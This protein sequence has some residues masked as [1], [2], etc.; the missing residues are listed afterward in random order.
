MRYAVI[1]AGGS[2]KRLWPLSRQ[3]KPKQVLKLIEGQTL[4]RKCFERLQGIFEPANILVVTN[5]DYV[6][7]VCDELGELPKENIVAEPV[8][9]DTAGAI[10]LAATILHKRDASAT[11]AVVTADQLLEP[12]EKFR[13]TLIAAISFIDENPDA[14]I[15]FGIK[16]LFPSTQ[17]GY[18][19]FGNVKPCAKAAEHVYAIDTFK[20][21]PNIETATRYFSDGHFFWNAGLF[22]CRCE[23]IL[24][25]LKTFLPDCVEPL[26]KIREGWATAN[27]QKMLEEW[28]PKLPKISIDYAVMEKAP[29]VHGMELDCRWMDLGSFS[30]LQNIIPPD[31][32]QNTVAAKYSELL[33]SKNNIIATE[34]NGHLIALIGVEN[35]IVAH[36]KDA[37]LVCPIDQADRLKELL[38]VIKSH[39]CEQFL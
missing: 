39:Q 9:R 23:T 31:H 22:V 15:T 38:D 7:T 10:G 26:A 13:Q 18:L 4:L 27:Q 19:K 17:F 36:S 16:P 11:M 30:A 29:Q 35:M 6:E 20:E 28:F 1:M 37:T 5:A 32:N 21:K 12:A 8:V 33:N 14:M 24:N 25:H 3:K 34:E 2:G